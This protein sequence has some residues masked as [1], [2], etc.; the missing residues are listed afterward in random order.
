[1]EPPVQSSF[2]FNWPRIDNIRSEL[3]QIHFKCTQSMTNWDELLN[4]ARSTRSI[5]HQWEDQVGFDK[6]HLM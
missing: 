4:F 1:M 5:E 2:K 3:F 6:V